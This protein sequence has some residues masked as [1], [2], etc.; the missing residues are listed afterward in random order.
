MCFGDTLERLAF[1]FS[2]KHA[3]LRFFPK[4]V[5]FRKTETQ[6]DGELSGTELYGFSV[7]NHILGL[8]NPVFPGFFGPILGVFREVGHF[9]KFPKVSHFQIFSK[10]TRFAKNRKRDVESGA[11][12]FSPKLV[13]FRFSPKPTRFTFF[14]KVDHFPKFLKV[15][16]FTKN[17]KRDPKN[18]HPTFFPKRSTFQNFQKL[19]SLR[20]FVK[21]ISF[22]KNSTPPKTV[23]A[24]PEITKRTV[25]QNFAK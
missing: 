21:S 24:D 7:R 15:S 13:T 5:T 1:P 8:K 23:Q 12:L 16:H 14:P 9:Q 18:G 11:Q 10:V 4:L 22:P 25:T 19:P 20:N 17:R 6:H 2:Q 3:T